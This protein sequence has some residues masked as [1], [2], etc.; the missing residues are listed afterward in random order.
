MVMVEYLHAIVSKMA[1]K[2]IVD[3]TTWF[4]K[5]KY[6][7]KNCFC[8]IALWSMKNRNLMKLSIAWFQNSNQSGTKL[9][10]INFLTEVGM[11]V[12][13]FKIRPQVVKDVYIRFLTNGFCPY[14]F[15][16]TFNLAAMFSLIIPG[17]IA[18]TLGLIQMLP[19][20]RRR[21][22]ER[23]MSGSIVVPG[24]LASFGLVCIIFGIITPQ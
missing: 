3:W 7:M 1:K 15:G 5:V 18:A 10:S 2:Q 8:G 21:A 14:S 24:I 9:V 4:M 19:P 22:A 16:N 12:R 23:G 13:W 17:A 20:M 11:N 6:R